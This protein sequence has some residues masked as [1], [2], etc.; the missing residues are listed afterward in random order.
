[1]MSLVPLEALAEARDKAYANA[2]R[3]GLSDSGADAWEKRG[4]QLEALRQKL[5]AAVIDSGSAVY[6]ANQGTLDATAEKL[7]SVNAS[8]T[9][10][11]QDLA[12]F[13]A[14]IGAVTT[15]VTKVLPLV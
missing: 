10:L 2:A 12:A 8:L 6:A 4:D 1:M 11:A 5:A 14:L 7:R 3:P 13:D 15:I 9:A